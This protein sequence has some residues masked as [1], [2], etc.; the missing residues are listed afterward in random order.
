MNTDQ[1]QNLA[2]ILEALETSKIRAPKDQEYVEEIDEE[3]MAQVIE[4]EYDPKPLGDHLGISLEQLP[5]VG[6]LENDELEILVGKILDTWAAY[7]YFADFSNNVSIRIA[8]KELLNV[9]ND[10]TPRTT[11]GRYHF[12]L[13]DPEDCFEFD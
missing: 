5:A 4:L 13:S 2:D 1:N 9:W 10:E 3:I 12:I 6:D 11:T 8:Y 7:N